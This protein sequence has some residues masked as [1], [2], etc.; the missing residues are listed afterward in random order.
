MRR[1]EIDGYL[2]LDGVKRNG[3][4]WNELDWSRLDWICC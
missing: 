4:G 2:M 1:D 3:M